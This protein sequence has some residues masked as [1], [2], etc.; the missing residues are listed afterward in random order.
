MLAR[1]NVCLYTYSHIHMVIETFMLMASIAAEKSLVLHAS[2]LSNEPHLP[3]AMRKE[4][5]LISK[6]YF[7]NHCFSLVLEMSKK[8]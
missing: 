3:K 4:I 1:K 5:K 8:L 2:H 7:P 6:N